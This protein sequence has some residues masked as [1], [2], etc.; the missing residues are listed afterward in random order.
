MF[1]PTLI[2]RINKRILKYFKPI[3]QPIRRKLINNT[4]F[5]VISNN[6]WGGMLSNYF[7]LR[8]NSPTVGCY[9][10]AEDYM[11]FINNLEY[12]LN[13]EIRIIEASESKN[14]EKYVAL[15]S[16]DVP[17]GVIDDVEIVFQ[18]YRDPV[19][20]K[21][22]WERRIDRINFDNIIF[23]FSQMNYCTEEHLKMFDEFE[24]NGGNCKKIMFVNKLRPDLKCAIYYR[25]FENEEGLL[26]D[27]YFFKRDYDLY[28]FI[29]EGKLI[30]K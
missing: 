21:Q 23:K 4:D 19:K 5:S 25:G 2:Q 27:S 28:A 24:F 15:N 7:G 13:T 18:H 16:G 9:F 11:K 14:Y 10:L 30:Q 26:N 29:N 8:K 1:K 6:C 20:A 17:I 3:L 22:T 12:Y